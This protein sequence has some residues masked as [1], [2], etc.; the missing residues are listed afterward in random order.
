MGDF[1][2][3]LRNSARTSPNRVMTAGV[4]PGRRKANAISRICGGKRFHVY[5][6][7]FAGRRSAVRVGQVKG[8][9]RK[10]VLRRPRIRPT[11]EL[12]RHAGD[13]RKDP[14]TVVVV[15]VSPRLLKEL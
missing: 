4:H 15:G 1:E 6:I 3:M 10:A 8:S 7:P 5:R 13:E 2:N 11:P 9:G 12:F 14:G